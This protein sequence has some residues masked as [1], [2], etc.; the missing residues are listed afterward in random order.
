MF[1]YSEKL[2]PF[3]FYVQVEDPSEAGLTAH[4]DYVSARMRE[5]AHLAR[6]RRYAYVIQ[7]TDRSFRQANANERTL[8]AQWIARDTELMQAT[9]VGVGFVLDSVLVRGALTAVFWLSRMPVP[10]RVHA[11][12]D[13]ALLAAIHTIED[14]HLPLPA[15]FRSQGLSIAQAEIDSLLRQPGLRARKA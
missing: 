11:S 6:E 15:G 8:L 10:H 9:A 7:I 1:R 13:Q 2:W 3:W 12:L 4:F 5:R 14:A